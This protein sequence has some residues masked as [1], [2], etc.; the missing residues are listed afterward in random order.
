MGTVPI[1]YNYNNPA[2][3]HHNHKTLNKNN[4]AEKLAPCWYL[5]TKTG[6]RSCDS[7]GLP[8]PL[9]TCPD[10]T[11]QPHLCTVSSI[12]TIALPGP[13]HGCERRPCTASRLPLLPTASIAIASAS[14]R[15]PRSCPKLP[16]RVASWGVLCPKNRNATSKST[17]FAFLGV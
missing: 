12:S 13:G 9:A 11:F 16:S 1:D 4:T 2:K 5:N 14:D 6:V 17:G 8:S 3:P 15:G 7:S 10:G